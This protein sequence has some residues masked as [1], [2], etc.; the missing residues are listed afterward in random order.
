MNIYLNKNNIPKQVDTPDDHVIKIKKRPDIVGLFESLTPY[1]EAG[2][3]PTEQIIQLKLQE[4][5][6]TLLATNKYFFPM[7]FDFTSPW[8]TEEITYEVQNL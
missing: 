7:L 1:F 3:E 4:G 6:H 5:I 2:I 8:K